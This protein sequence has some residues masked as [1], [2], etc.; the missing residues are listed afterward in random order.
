MS[1]EVSPYYKPSMKTRLILTFG[2]LGLLGLFIGWMAFLLPSDQFI[3]GISLLALYMAPGAGKESIVPVMIGFGFSWWLVLIGIV[4]IDMT[5][6]VLI[7]C[8]FDLLLKIPVVGNLLRFLTEKT[9]TFLG[10]HPW[11]K[12]LSLAGLFIFM[13]IPFMGSSAID[14]SIIGRL[15]SIHPKMLLPII[16]VGSILAT[17]TMAFGARAIINLWI[18]NPVYAIIAVIIIIVICIAIYK[19]WQKFTAKR[20]PKKEN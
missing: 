5:L 13:Y 15:L 18:M 19:I 2:I 11:I 3:L 6:A 12:G 1:D 7:S 20:F 16:L 14:T 9:N 8:N 10:S 4:I 17:L